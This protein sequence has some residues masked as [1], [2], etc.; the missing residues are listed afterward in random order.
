MIRR[1]GSRAGPE[2]MCSRA[3]QSATGAKCSVNFRS[4]PTVS[5]SQST[6]PRSKI[7]YDPEEVRSVYYAEVDRLLKR[8]T[9]A[10]RVVVFDHIVRNP[11]L[12]ERGEKGARPPAKMVTTTTASSPRRAASATICRKKPTAC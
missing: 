12:A 7:F 11:V 10:E 4:I 8:V 6:K 9:G 2:N 1:P 5:Y 3:S